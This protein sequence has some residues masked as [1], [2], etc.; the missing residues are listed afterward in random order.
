MEFL[1]L[2]HPLDCP[3]CDKAGE[4][5]L[6]DNS[7]DHGPGKARHQLEKRVY[8]IKDFSPALKMYMNRCIHCT[9]CVRFLKE[10]EGKEEFALYQRG[11]YVDV[12]TYLEHNLSNN[13]Q[14][15]LSDVCP[16]GALVSKPA[17]YTARVFDMEA[18]ASVCASC[19]AG[20]SVYVDRWRNR[21]ARL[22]PRPNLQVN[23]WWM[24]D[25]GRYGWPWIEQERLESVESGDWD[26]AMTAAG[27]AL[28]SSGEGF[29]TAAGIVAPTASCE[30]IYLFGK[31]MG[32]IGGPVAAWYGP[33]GRIDPTLKNDFLH[34]N[35]PNPNTVGMEVVLGE[36]EEIQS[37][38]GRIER[39]D[40][41]TVVVLGAGLDAA[42]AARLAGAE[43]VVVISSHRNPAVAAA[44]LALPGAVW[45][46]KTGTFVNG[47]GQ[48][49]LF[50]QALDMQTDARP[51]WKILS[52]LL[53]TC[54]IC[55]TYESPEAVFSE[56][57]HQ[58]MPFF[59]LTYASI[60]ETGV[61]LAMRIGR[62]EKR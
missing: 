47:D 32:A 12:G 25:T 55:E 43:A 31:L 48:L 23:E 20:C 37:L 8:P 29:R 21:V 27:Q 34:R 49:Q 62:T 60:T 36:M 45:L 56:M 51:D 2:N 33:E 6:Q 54:Q 11:A 30:E 38:L 35:D 5:M 13:Y 58:V 28:L 17:L 57:A 44:T 22:R 26:E 41:E 7:Y 9:R 42:S 39:G 61:S 19:S 3:W 46:E 4:C 24:C 15:C 10:V 52:D 50:G 18:R 53:S 1:L 59:G 14:G 40:I 16:V